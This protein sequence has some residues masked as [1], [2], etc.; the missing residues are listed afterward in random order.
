MA[1]SLFGSVDGD[2]MIANTM[3]AEPGD[4]EMLST[5]KKWL[6]PGSQGGAS[7]GGTIGGREAAR[8]HRQ[9]LPLVGG[10]QVKL[11]QRDKPFAHPAYWA[12]FVVGDPR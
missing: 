1:S 7:L 8:H 5:R 4:A 2:E 11:P 12:A 9:A 3:P 6:L 10:K